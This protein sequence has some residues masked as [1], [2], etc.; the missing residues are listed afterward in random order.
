MRIYAS[1]L[2]QHV[3]KEAIYDERNVCVCL[4][5]AQKRALTL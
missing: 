3:P 2:Q 4:K 1:K 5:A